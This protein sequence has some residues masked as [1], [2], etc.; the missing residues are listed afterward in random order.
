M[1][2][3][4]RL[5]IHLISTA[6]FLLSTCHSTAQENH[7]TKQPFQVEMIVFQHEAL[8]DDRWWPPI[9]LNPFAQLIN[10]PTHHYR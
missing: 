1:V 6:F 5:V 3:K 2:N 8:S 4:N 7:F 9:Q 10:P